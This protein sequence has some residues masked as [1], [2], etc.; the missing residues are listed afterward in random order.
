MGRRVAAVA[1]ASVLVLAASACGSD[2]DT[3]DPGDDVDVTTPIGETPMET[4]P[5]DPV[6]T[7]LEP[8]TT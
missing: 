1:A 4:I 8:V 5:T 2:D 6:E 7:M 3:D